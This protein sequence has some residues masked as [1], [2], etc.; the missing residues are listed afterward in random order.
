MTNAE[1]AR[2]GLGA[3]CLV[4]V[5]GLVVGYLVQATAANLMADA[6]TYCYDVDWPFAYDMADSPRLFIFEGLGWTLLYSLCLPLGFGLARRLLRDRRRLLRPGATA[7]LSAALL[8]GVFTT[9][10]MLNISARDGMYHQARCPHG[11]P[12]WW[13]GWLPARPGPNPCGSGPCPG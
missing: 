3:G 8:T 11:T 5:A 12:P 7:L 6:W 10:L 2:A 9:D 4:A 13:P 1:P